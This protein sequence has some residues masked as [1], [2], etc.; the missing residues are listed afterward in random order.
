[1][2]DNQP[3][4][5]QPSPSP[6]QDPISLNPSAGGT[7]MSEDMARSVAPKA[8]FGLNKVLPKSL[9]EFRQDFMS[10]KENEVRQEASNQIDATKNKAL[11]DKIKEIATQGKLTPFDLDHARDLSAKKTDP[12]TVIEQQYAKNFIH[13]VDPMSWDPDSDSW[14]K[15]ANNNRPEQ[16]KLF[17]DIGEHIIAKREIGLRELKER[18][19]SFEKQSIPSYLWDQLKE[20]VLPGYT[21]IMQRGAVP[22]SSFF[23]G[24]RGTNIKEQVA[25]LLTMPNDQMAHTLHDVLDR[26]EKHDP[27][28]ALQFA[29]AFVS[30]STSEEHLNNMMSLPDLV[31]AGSAVAGTGKLLGNTMKSLVKSSTLT[32]GLSIRSAAAAGSGDLGEAAVFRTVESL[33]SKDAIK[34]SMDALHDVLRPDTSFPPGA[35]PGNFGAEQMNRLSENMGG[36]RERLVNLVSNIAKVERIPSAMATEKAVR[37]MKEEI[38]GNYHGPDNQ[39]LNISDPYKNPMTNTWHYDMYLGQPSG[40]Y[41]PRVDQAQKWMDDNFPGGRVVDHS[42]V[43]NEGAGAGFYVKVSRPYNE[44]MRTTRDGL[45]STKNASTPHSLVNNYLAKWRTPEETLSKDQR[46][47]RKIATYA[48]GI[49]EKFAGEE[50]EDIR[51][52]A[53]WTVPGSPKKA[54]YL[55][56]ER[57]VTTMSKWPD[58]SG[59]PLKS[60]KWFKDPE[61]V[62]GFYQNNYG[63]LPDPQEIRAYFSFKNLMT[64]DWTA[65]NARIY[66][67]LSRLGAEEHTF[68]VQRPQTVAGE[69]FTMT[70]DKL[71]R[72][73]SPMLRG[74]V[75]KEL[76]GGED[77]IMVAGDKV[78]D[79]K[80]Y[81]GGKSP[82]M[83]PKLWQ[84]LKED[85]KG[86]NRVVIRIADPETRPLEGFGD[87]GNKKVRYVIA[88]SVKTKPL[89]YD[90][91]PKREGGHIDYEYDNYIKQ[92]RVIPENIGGKFVHHYEGDTT[93]MAAESHG[94]GVAY[95]KLM[96]TARELI[97]KGKMAEARA[98]VNSKLNIPWKE[99]SGHFKPTKVNGQEKPPRFSS[100]EPFKVVPKG[101]MILD[102]DNDLPGRYPDTFKDGT[103]EGS[104]MRQYQVAYTGQRDADEL[105][106]IR[107]VGTRGN[108]VFKYEPAKQV[109][110][111]PTMNRALSRIINSSFNDD[112]KITAM[113]HWIQEAKP[114]LN[115]KDIRELEAAPFYHFF[116]GEFKT[117]ATK[118]EGGKINTLEANRM[119]IKQFTGIQNKTELWLHSVAQKAAD[120][121]YEK[122][123]PKGDLVPT[124]GLAHL[125]DPLRFLRSVVFNM[126]MGFFNIPQF[127]VHIMTYM[128]VEGIAG[129]KN[130]T[131]GAMAAMLHG[132]SR[133]NKH[134]NIIEHMGSL[135]ENFGWK[136]GWFREAMETVDRTGFMHEHGE[137]A[138]RDDTF[139][140]EV[141]KRNRNW[142]LHSGQMFFRGGVRALRA[143]SWYT[144][145]L[146]HR[147]AN[148]TGPITQAAMSSILERADILSHNMS[149]ASSSMLHTG[150]MSIPAQF[151]TYFLRLSELMTGS[152]LTPVE[153]ARL[154]GVNALTYGFP[155]ATGLYGVLELPWVVA[156][157]PVEDSIRNFAR[158]H[159][160]VIGDNVAMSTFMEG[161]GSALGAVI[162]GGGDPHKGEWYNVGSRYGPEGLGNLAEIFNK[163]KTI[164]DIFGGAA[165]SSVKNTWAQSSGFRMW[166]N[167]LITGENWPLK[168]EDYIDPLKE[169]SAVNNWYKLIAA[170]HFGKVMNKSETMISDTS[171]ARAV[172][173]FLSGL[174]PTENSE[175]FSMQEN[176]KGIKGY[177]DSL[178][179]MFLR[180]TQRAIRAT[181]DGNPQQAEDYTRRA[182]AYLELGFPD[183][184]YKELVRKAATRTDNDLLTSQYWDYFTRNITP[185]KEKGN[186]EQLQRQ[187]QRIQDK[188]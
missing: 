74:I 95:T 98:F 155:A 8:E 29:Q 49:I 116:K 182:R 11:N 36:F 92:A 59:D 146:E 38:K 125:T 176:K 76:P 82:E 32:S 112:Y 101:S 37:A 45:L 100:K 137:Y 105:R 77:T 107:D 16:V 172:L 178:E 131:S 154:F 72:V 171:P 65:R 103:R 50:A 4:S 183:D 128:N 174:Q 157:S 68:S 141:F 161:I 168:P 80:F 185:G 99:F 149:R 167:S 108:P 104:D 133:F 121:V 1:M 106:A 169:I 162:T 86:G 164:W 3:I 44:E 148:P 17:K 5:L 88:K 144:A 19:E 42:A 118:E 6:T 109:D 75:Q 79:E 31:Y 181:A 40:D 47:Q 67:N 140:P 46:E 173:Q 124:W 73:D 35:N 39:I 57:M 180:E 64:L 177:Q 25:Q 7:S 27:G 126:K 132:Y 60:G 158:D 20:N 186:L 84:T 62:E 114:Y 12:K 52:L 110:P 83:S 153:K 156:G 33:A 55:E 30:Q 14:L 102:M 151:Y 111:I 188:K 21:D 10:G 63:R 66:T 175:L 136:P 2:V 127:M 22:D 163:D 56:W 134:P 13:T 87:T 51:K 139:N 170:L 142:F 166:A 85:V 115:V 89:S 184:R 48:A 69:G 150:V 145:F 152:R 24:L 165:V 71:E 117:G 61:E 90:I 18:Q 96:N 78:G 26:M 159:G 70:T 122:L 143:G 41:W 187:L 28:L 135:T 81:R 147:Q 93:A 119:K 9:E 113:E 130:A 123:G 97:D 58:P 129:P 138:L 160:Y 94:S 43:G 53:S 15:D 34:Q 91:L 54:R 120:S 23:T 179:K